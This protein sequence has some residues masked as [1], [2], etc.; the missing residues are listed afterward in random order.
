M[1]YLTIYT[2]C[3]SNLNLIRSEDL[4]EIDCDKPAYR[5]KSDS[6]RVP[7]FVQNSQFEFHITPV[8]KILILNLDI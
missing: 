5:H 1:T 3:L 4:K 8:F 7:F 6:I 2:L